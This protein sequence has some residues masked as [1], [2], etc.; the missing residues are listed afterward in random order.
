MLEEVLPARF[1]GTSLDYQLAE[2]EAPGGA[3]RL[4]LR[5]SPSLGPLKAADLRATLFDEL[6]RGGSADR[7]QVSL[8]RRA[9]TL[10]VRREAP[11]STRAGKVLPFQLLTHARARNRPS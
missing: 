2:D 3:V 8:W 4:V 7:Y 10:Q 1:G 11:I 9:G 5:V 6:G